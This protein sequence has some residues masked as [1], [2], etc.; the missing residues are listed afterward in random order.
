[1][2]TSLSSAAAVQADTTTK[3]KLETGKIAAMGADMEI[4]LT[5]LLL[6]LATVLIFSVIVLAMYIG[7]LRRSVA[8]LRS[9]PVTLIKRGPINSEEKGSSSTPRPRPVSGTCSWKSGSMESVFYVPSRT[10]SPEA[11]RKNDA[12]LLVA[13]T[14]ACNTSGLPTE[15]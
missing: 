8:S 3:L 4:I 15:S 13:N 1:M 7:R 2:F 5:G 14:A 12:D 9:N 11:F 6:A 10:G